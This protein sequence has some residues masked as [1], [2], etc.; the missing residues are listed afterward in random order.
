MLTTSSSQQIEAAVQE[1]YDSASEREWQ[2]MDRHRTEFAVTWRVLAE[3]LPPPP[4]RILD[5]GGGPGRYAIELARQ[6]YE[7][8]L[9]DLSA[10]NLALAQAKADEAGVSFTAIVQG[11]ATDLSRF[12]DASFDA[13][14]LMGPLYHLLEEQERLS[15]VA[16][17][18]RVVRP[19]GLVFAAFV[20]R[21]AA[22]RWAAANEPTW[23]VDDPEAAQT[24]LD[25]GRLPPRPHRPG[26]FIGYFAHP[27]EVV[28]LIRRAGLEVRAVL[29]VDALVS[30]IE[31][32]VNQLTGA[33]WERWADLSTRVASD[34]SCM[35]RQSTCWWWRAGRRGG[36]RC[37]VWLERLNTAGIPYKIVGSTCLALH[38]VPLTPRDI[39]VE[40]DAAGAYRIQALWPDAVV[41]PVVLREESTY[42]THLGHLSIDGVVVEIM[43]GMERLDDGGWVSTADST[44]TVVELDGVPV[45]LAWLEEEALAYVRRGR[46]ERT[47]QCL[48]YCDRDRLLAL[49]RREVPTAVI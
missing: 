24:L 7:V 21:Y 20:T 22:H 43:G 40:T 48:P 5:C 12:D 30:Q 8:T 17:V 23:I 37:V 36:K 16:E 49:L 42:R 3:H 10:G 38:G 45:R 28:P 35:E 15:A 34:P 27:D 46:L 31:E 4:A 44:E 2:R 13:V 29:G 25:T 47:A 1:L 32:G 19:G 33:A 11:T 26:G 9:F 14:L 41:D 18:K 6:G 39:D